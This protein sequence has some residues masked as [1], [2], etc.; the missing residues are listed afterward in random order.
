[1]DKKKRWARYQLYLCVQIQGRKSI[2]TNFLI[3]AGFNKELKIKPGQT[4]NMQL[5]NEQQGNYPS[6]SNHALPIQNQL[7]YKTKYKQFKKLF[8]S[9]KA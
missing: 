3:L 4:P 8:G 1:M 7:I 6:Y 2:Q 5:L 9:R